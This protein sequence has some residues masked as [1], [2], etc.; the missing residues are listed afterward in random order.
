[1]RYVHLLYI[2]TFLLSNSLFA[3]NSSSIFNMYVCMHMCVCV[4]VCVCVCAR[5]HRHAHP[6]VKKPLLLLI[7]A[8]G[9]LNGTEGLQVMWKQIN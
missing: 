4:C 8:E 2:D 5:A 3:L 6:R 1:M 9:P 7:F